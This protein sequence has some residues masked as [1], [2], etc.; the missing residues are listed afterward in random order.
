VA[1]DAG[2]DNSKASGLFFAHWSAF[3]ADRATIRNYILNKS[4][5]SYVQVMNGLVFLPPHLPAKGEA[6]QQ[7]RLRLRALADLC[8][9]YETEFILIVPPSLTPRDQLL[10]R[11]AEL[12][13]I[14]VDIPVAIGSLG[15]E[16][17]QD[18]FHLN[19]EGAALFTDA[20]AADFKARF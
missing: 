8:H 2:L 9:R 3:Y 7:A 12:E 14:P 6:L 5:P 10:A 4:D 15:R 18:G 16:Y 13:N 17:F 19:K 1:R 11:A 20:L